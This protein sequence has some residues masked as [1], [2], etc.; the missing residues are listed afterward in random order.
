MFLVFLVN[1]ED[2]TRLKENR[3]TTNNNGEIKTKTLPQERKGK[4]TPRVSHSN[5]HKA[6]LLVTIEEEK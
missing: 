1:L 5:F 4:A 3:D 2:K 6:L